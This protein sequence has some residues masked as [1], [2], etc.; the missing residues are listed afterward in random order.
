MSI[1]LQCPQ[2][3]TEIT[4]EPEKQT[5]GSCPKCG[6]E[7]EVGFT[8]LDELE[9]EYNEMMTSMMD[10]IK[11]ATSSKLAY[12]AMKFL[13]TLKLLAEFKRYVEEDG[14]GLGRELLLKMILAFEM[15]DDLEQDD[16]WKELLRQYE[17]N[18]EDKL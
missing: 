7:F 11:S 17:E 15:S 6:V 16:N 10:E 8:N 2:C 12:M 1:I 4:I 9:Q 5:E 3:G 13:N 18:K 14:E